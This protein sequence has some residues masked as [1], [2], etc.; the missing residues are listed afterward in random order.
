MK[1]ECILTMTKCQN[2]KLQVLPKMSILAY[3]NY[4]CVY[5]YM[6]VLSYYIQT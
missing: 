3:Y 6:C 1:L 5:A 4:I 2:E